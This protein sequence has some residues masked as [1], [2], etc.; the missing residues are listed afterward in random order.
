MNRAYT[1]VRKHAYL[2]AVNEL[3]S[4]CISSRMQTHTHTKKNSIRFAANESKLNCK[5]YILRVTSV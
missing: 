5:F 4:N 3:S 1:E 2:F